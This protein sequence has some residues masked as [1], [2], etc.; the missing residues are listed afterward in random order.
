MKVE[1]IN[2]NRVQITMSMDEL[3]Q[4]KI[5]IK[6]IE[7]DSNKARMLFLELM[8]ET[9]MTCDFSLEHSQV[10]VEASST[11]NNEFVVTITKVENFPDISKFDI[12]GN[13]KKNNS[14]YLD[15]YSHFNVFEFNTFD[16]VIKVSKSLNNSK[17][18]IGKNSLYKYNDKYFLIF[19]KYSLKNVKFVKTASILNEYCEY[20][21][22]NNISEISLKEKAKCLIENKAIQN[23]SK[24][25]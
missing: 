5:S 1:V 22:E 15:Y 24:Y 2:K 23:L 14:S 11:S 21:Y 10:F 3:S 6:D 20:M 12:L 9:E 8:E 4:R 16:D 7:K 17:C 25:F 19:S 18:F 13:S